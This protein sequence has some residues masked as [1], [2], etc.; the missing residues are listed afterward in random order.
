MDGD[1]LELRRPRHR[2]LTTKILGKPGPNSLGL[3][4]GAKADV[5]HGGVITASS[6][7]MPDKADVN[8][9][10]VRLEQ[11]GNELLNLATHMTLP[12]T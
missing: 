8:H 5:V 6:R 2:A 10:G 7:R 1:A 11:D 12:F 9:K 4:C 3:S